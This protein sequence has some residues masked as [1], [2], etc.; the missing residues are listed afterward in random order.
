MVDKFQVLVRKVEPAA[1]AAAVKASIPSHFPKILED[2]VPLPVIEVFRRCFRIVETE[3]DARR[4]DL[5]EAFHKG[6]K[7]LLRIVL[8]KDAVD[9]ETD[10][11]LFQK[12]IIGFLDEMLHM[13][14]NVKTGNLLLV[15][16]QKSQDFFLGLGLG[17]GQGR[18]D[19]D[20]VRQ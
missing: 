10:R 6:Y 17:H 4:M 1:H 14:R 7:L 19:I 13:A 20:L 8:I 16:L 15:P 3:L 2:L 9:P 18:I 5:T 11:Q 12:G